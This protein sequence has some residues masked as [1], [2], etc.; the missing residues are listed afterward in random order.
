MRCDVERSLGGVQ[1]LD[2]TQAGF[3]NGAF[4]FLGILERDTDLVPK[5]RALIGLESFE[6]LV[7]V[8]FNEI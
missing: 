8:V 7:E 5:F 4:G 3:I 6:W 1:T 2:D